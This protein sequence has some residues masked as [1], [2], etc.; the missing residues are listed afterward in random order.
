[1]WSVFAGI[2]FHPVYRIATK[3]M[4]VCTY[5]I[6]WVGG[7]SICKYYGYFNAATR[8]LH[9]RGKKITRKTSLIDSY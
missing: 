9:G 4:Q 3:A 5:N 7:R 8:N 6:E 2:Y 1:M